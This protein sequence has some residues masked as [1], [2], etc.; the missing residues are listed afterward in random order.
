[1]AQR[2]EE[3]GLERLQLRRNH[4]IKIFEYIENDVKRA[5]A[6]PHR[7]RRSNR[8]A[9]PEQNACERR[10]LRRQIRTHSTGQGRWRRAARCSTCSP[11]RTM[12]SG[13]TTLMTLASA[14]HAPFVT[15]QRRFSH[16]IAPR[17]GRDNLRRWQPHAGRAF[18]IGRQCRSREKRFNAS[19]LPA[20]AE[21]ALAVVLVRPRQR[22]V[23]PLAGNAVGARDDVA[24]DDKAAADPCARDDAEDHLGPGRGAVRGFGDAQSNLHRWRRAPAVG[25]GLRDPAATAC[26]STRSSS[27]FSRGRWTRR[28]CPDADS[29]GRDPGSGLPRVKSRG[30]GIR[31]W[32]V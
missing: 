10:L 11:P 18:V 8:R 14:R 7:A 4:Y 26:Q 29:N 5:T 25:D 16:A 21:R 17:G 30:S 13:S 12:T 2:A 6:R 23:P 32:R 1:M 9:R 24:V 28:W 20:V 19:A 22:V 3:I 15:F 31:C 27:H